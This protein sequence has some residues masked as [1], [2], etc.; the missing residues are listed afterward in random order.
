MTLSRRAGLAAA[1][2]ALGSALAGCSSATPAPAPVP[3]EPPAPAQPAT[4]TLPDAPTSAPP[5][6]SA[7]PTSAIPGIPDTPD[8]LPAGRTVTALILGTDSDADDTNTD[9][10]VIAQLSADR[11]QVNLCSVPRDCYVPINGGAK[12]KVNSALKN[13]GLA[14][15]KK[16]VS[17]LFG[18]LQFDYVLQTNFADFVKLVTLFDGFSVQNRIAASFP[19]QDGSKTHFPAGTLTQH[20][21]GWLFYVRQRKQLPEGDLDRTERHR[22]VITGMI[23]WAQ[24]LLASPAQFITVAKGSLKCVRVSGNLTADT[25]LGLA[26]ALKAIQAGNI[27]SVRV[28]ISGYG[29]AGG[30]GDVDYVD[31]AKQAQLVAA[32]KAGDVSGYVR[33][34]PNG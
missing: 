20:G 13:H 34:Y 3:S 23:R 26:P 10:I 14:G 8:P 18:G 30:W 5:A 28:P 17:D 25:V 12:G 11:R 32:L 15:A 33:A 22:A 2:G 9:V 29:S 4:P 6:T 21:D 24:Q 7:T 27:A 19:H 16:T 1:L 31:T